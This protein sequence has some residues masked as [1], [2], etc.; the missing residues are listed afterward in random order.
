MRARDRS[1]AK[2]HSRTISLGWDEMGR[3]KGVIVCIES[4]GGRIP[5]ERIANEGTSGSS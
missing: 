3:R 5:M 2:P 4:G 1:L